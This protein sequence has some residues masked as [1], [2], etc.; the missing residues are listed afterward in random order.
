MFLWPSRNMLQVLTRRSNK[1]LIGLK[2]DVLNFWQ[3]WPKATGDTVQWP[4]QLAKKGWSIFSV[5]VHHLRRE[6]S[7]PNRGTEQRVDK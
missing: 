5:I 3:P 2:L 1:G 4:R 7:V 6:R